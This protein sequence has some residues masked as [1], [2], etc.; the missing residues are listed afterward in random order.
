M[1]IPKQ[2]RGA[3]LI[4]MAMGGSAFAQDPPQGTQGTSDEATDPVTCPTPNVPP[5]TAQQPAQAAPQAAPAPAPTY[6]GNEPAPSEG[7]YTAETWAH[8][9]GLGLSVGGGVEDFSGSTMRDT[10][11]TGGSWTARLTFGTHSY[12]AGEAAYIGSAQSIQRL[13][14]ASNSELIGNGAQADLRINGTTNYPVQP[15]V[16]GG[17]AWRHYSLNTSGTNFSDVIDH[18]DAFEV[19]LGVGVAGYVE[20]VMLE[21]RGEYRFGWADHDI[22]TQA[23]G[24]TP[25]MDRWG[26]TGNIGYSF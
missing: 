9:V 19:P 12:I 15:F 14:L 11:G 6:Y 26:V 17:A 23:N 24:G 18:A 13:G 4:V 3:A 5:A 25:L 22:V 8:D 21:A 1:A 16:Y 10:T 20:G 7:Q 2:L